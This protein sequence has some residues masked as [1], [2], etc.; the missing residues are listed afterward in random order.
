MRTDTTTDRVIT[1][2]KVRR[3]KGGEGDADKIA[4]ANVI[5]KRVTIGD[6]VL[7]AAHV[8]PPTSLLIVQLHSS[9]ALWRYARNPACTR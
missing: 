2:I 7:P 3:E 6:G 8:V 4:V 1:I 5:W 9:S